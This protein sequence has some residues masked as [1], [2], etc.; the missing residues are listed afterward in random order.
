VLGLFYR[1]LTDIQKTEG[2]YMPF[3][4]GWLHWFIQRKRRKANIRAGGYRTARC[5]L[6]IGKAKAQ[7]C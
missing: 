1:Q 5:M 2:K 3:F 6:T 4:R 7:K